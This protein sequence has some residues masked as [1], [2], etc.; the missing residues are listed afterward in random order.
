MKYL[1]LT[2]ATL[3]G[4]VAL[5]EMGCVAPIPSAAAVY[6]RVEP[7]AVEI[8]VNGR[9]A[10]SGSIVD[11]GGSVLIAAHML[12]N[13][14]ETDVKLEAHSPALGRHPVQWVALDRG[15]DLALLQLPARETAYP[16]LQ[17]ARRA[18][19]PGEPVYL[20]G[21][22]VFRHDVM[23]AGRVARARPTY[24]F[25]DGAFREI[26]HISA[27]S[28][29]G[30]SGGPWV[31]ARGRIFGVQSA[32]MTI[33]GG[34]QGI[35]YAAPL[36]SLQTLLETRRDQATPTLQ[37]GVE[38]LWSQDP[39]F[40]K[41]LPG[42]LRGLVVRQLQPNGPAGRA[43]LKEWDIITTLDGW[44]VER[45]EDYVNA[46]RRHRPGETIRMRATDRTGENP[47]DLTIRLVP[48]Q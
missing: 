43:G 14:S 46:L 45:T 28:P 9:M 3:L 29:I 30:T 10:G 38:E 36:A 19:R 18:P 7:A 39:G 13:A 25:Y 37:M 15:H 6:E 2:I 22:P 21:A 44:P 35:A 31:N 24:E 32:A 41:P 8:L 11:A 20:Y 42:S 48:I 23:I 40:L 17:L 16:H 1:R 33:K 47:R 27:I 5:G 34:H 4:V 26:V 12:P